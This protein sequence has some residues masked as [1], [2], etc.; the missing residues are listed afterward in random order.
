[1][2][3]VWV[4]YTYLIAVN[5][6]ELLSLKSLH[7]RQNPY[8]PLKVKTNTILRRLTMVMAKIVILAI[9]IVLKSA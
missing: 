3:I 5:Y 7:V 4:A 6:L 2:E 9:T 1:M 8:H